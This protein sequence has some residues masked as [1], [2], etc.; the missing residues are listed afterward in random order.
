M[1]MPVF[2][3]LRNGKKC[4]LIKLIFVFGKQVVAF[5][6]RNH[7]DSPHLD[8]MDYHAMSDDVLNLANYL[9]FENFSLMGHSMGGR[10]AMTFALKY[11][12]R[13]EKL[14]IVDMSPDTL[15]AD[16]KEMEGE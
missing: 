8:V 5:D 16:F 10:T 6:A 1:L 2:S 14:V 3:F 12:E 9:E 15:G 11:P 4:F 7:G 13:L